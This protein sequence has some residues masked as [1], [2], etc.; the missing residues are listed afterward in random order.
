VNVS[1]VLLRALL[2]VPCACSWY[3]VPILVY[4]G[5][6]RAF[7]ESMPR[8]QFCRDLSLLRQWGV[9][10]VPLEEAC[11]Y[12][13][14]HTL[15]DEPS[16]ALTFDDGYEEIFSFVYPLLR[17]YNIPATVFVWARKL[18]TPGYLTVQECVD[19]CAHGL[20]TIG[21][22]GIHHLHLPRFSDDV[23]RQEFVG[24]RRMLA[25]RL[26]VAVDFF[27]YPWGAMSPREAAYA[28]EAG[29]RA[30][31]ATNASLDGSVRARGVFTLRRMTLTRRDSA[32]RLWAKVSGYATITA[33]RI[34]G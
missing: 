30:A 33:R 24:S 16:V 34:Y 21:S 17:E 12:T 9:R 13:R 1:Q 10:V 23:S 18:G 31:C 25:Q 19:M 15:P 14:T 3:Q 11:R 29:Y 20:V 8:E 4:H 32:M 7:G 28:A 26:G 22:H 5:F 6:G 27:A 2:K